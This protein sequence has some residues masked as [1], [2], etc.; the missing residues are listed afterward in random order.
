MLLR[1]PD[2]RDWRYHTPFAASSAPESLRVDASTKAPAPV[3]QPASKL[4]SEIPLARDRTSQSSLPPPL[5]ST[6][7]DPIPSLHIPHTSHPSLRSHSLS[8]QLDHEKV[9]RRASKSP[10]TSRRATPDPEKAAHEHRSMRSVPSSNPISHHST[11][12][13]EDEDEDGSDDSRHHAV[14]ILVSLLV[15]RK[16]SNVL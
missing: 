5:A 6:L 16:I 13:Y 3:H 1:Q 14:W 12:V 2:D 8:T 15:N 4:C 11:V 9:E 7:R 10:W